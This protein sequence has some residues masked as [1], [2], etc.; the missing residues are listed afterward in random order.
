MDDDWRVRIDLRDHGRAHTLLE[1]LDAFELEHQLETSFHDRV[2]VSREN[3]TLFL[4]A[5][6]RQQAEQAR[7]LARRFAGEHSWEVDFD[8]RR[9]HPTAEAWEDPDVPL[10]STAAEQAAEHAE[11][12]ATERAQPIPEFEV[13]VECSTREAAH[14]LASRLRDEGLASVQR[15][16]YVL[17]GAAD[18]DQASRLADRI[19]VEAPPGSIVTAEGTINAVLARVGP[20]PFAIFGGLGG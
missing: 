14:E 10:P 16:H 15:S 8:L 13:R 7:E 6:T 11:R 20:N 2:I 1:R 12:I 18:E 19:R 5:G 3:S 9:W 17:V 4:Y